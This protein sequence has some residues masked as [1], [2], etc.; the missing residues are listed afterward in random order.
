MRFSEYV[1]IGFYAILS[2]YLVTYVSVLMRLLGLPIL[3]FVIVALTLAIVLPLLFVQGLTGLLDQD[4]RNFSE[5]HPSR[6]LL[7]VQDIHRSAIIMELI[8]VVLAVV[9]VESLKTGPELSDVLTSASLT[10]SLVELVLMASILNFWRPHPRFRLLASLDSETDP[11]REHNATWL[12]GS[13]GCFN[14]ILHSNGSKVLLRDDLN[15]ESLL[16]G[17][18]N[19]PL[20][21]AALRLAADSG[22]TTRFIQEVSSLA[23]KYPNEIIERNNLAWQIKTHL[24]TILGV[25]LAIVGILISLSPL[26]IPIFEYIVRSWFN[27]L[28]PR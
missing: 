23:H 24:S 9:L 25:G 22:D 26:L 4:T 20:K 12:D 21:I 16:F 17:S 28:N 27:L 18:I 10:F 6:F 5:T 19:R 3:I 14:A 2:G 11:E 13:L 8:G 15:L 7:K 1:L